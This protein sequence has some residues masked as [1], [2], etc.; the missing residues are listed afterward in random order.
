LFNTAPDWTGASWAHELGTLVA[1][2]RPNHPNFDG[3]PWL[4]FVREAGGFAEPREVRVTTYSPADPER[5]LAHM[6][7]ISWI[8][9]LPEAERLDMLA[10]MRTIVIGG[11]TPDQFALHFDIGLTR[12]LE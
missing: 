5:V 7:S 8:A 11:E 3:R 12:L 6:A 2:S 1:D 4:A 9:G 10:R